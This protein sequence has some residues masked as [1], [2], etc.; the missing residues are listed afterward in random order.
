[1]N[2]NIQNIQNTVSKHQHKHRMQHV[3]INKSVMTY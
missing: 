1:L 3:K 2:E